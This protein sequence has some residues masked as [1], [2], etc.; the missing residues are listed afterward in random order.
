MEG[1][2]HVDIAITSVRV[3]K[4]YRFGKEIIFEKNL[5]LSL[6]D[7]SLD[8]NDQDCGS[9]RLIARRTLRWKLPEDAPNIISVKKGS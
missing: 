5:H 7:D 1:P 8:K 6:G 2:R 9:P 4:A 3:N